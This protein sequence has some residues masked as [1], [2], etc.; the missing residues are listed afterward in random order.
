MDGDE[1]I[2]PF[3]EGIAPH[4]ADVDGATLYPWI[5]QRAVS[6][7]TVRL[8]RVA[9]LP[10]EAFVD[11]AT[12]RHDHTRSSVV[13]PMKFGGAVT[14]LLTFAMTERERAWPDDLV[15]RFELIA[16][17]F[18]SALGR[19]EAELEL[20]AATTRILTAVDVA[21]LGFFHM[22]RQGD[23]YVLD[24]RS[25]ELLGRPAERTSRIR[26]FWL[27]H[28]H[29]DDREQPQA[30]GREL[31]SGRVDGATGE[32][33]YLHDQRGVIWLRHSTRAVS[34]GDANSGLE[35]V[36]VFQDI[37]QDRQQEGSLR[38]ALAE[39]ERLQQ[40]LQHENVSLREEVKSLRGLTDIRGTSTAIPTTLIEN[41]LV[42][43][44]W[45]GN[46]REL[47]NTI[48]RAMIISPGPRLRIALPAV[49]TSEAAPAQSLEQLERAHVLA[50]LPETGWRVSGPRGAAKLLGL[51]PS[52]L[53]HRMKK[54]GIVRPGHSIR[55]VRPNSPKYW[56][57]PI[58]GRLTSP[59]RCHRAPVLHGLLTPR[60]QVSSR[61]PPALRGGS[62][63]ALIC[64]GGD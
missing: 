13:V 7:V 42:G 12:L 20:R 46:V 27:E 29:P 59:S 48:E 22:S 44:E 38:K 43:Y 36:G 49:A 8:E 9:D 58:A 31:A 24:A 3:G 10:V 14:G 6:G 18:A 52:T 57:F 2:V 39:V 26:E 63:F 47:R 4:R 54:M 21:G 33:R 60:Q 35:I 17:L 1:S 11:A 19:K 61:S 32:Y 5:T 28:V 62:A 45:P 53:E 37:T 55:A 16:R 23:V 51:R 56:E 25:R 34:E 15:A 30:L 41:E 64:H 40:Q 50:V